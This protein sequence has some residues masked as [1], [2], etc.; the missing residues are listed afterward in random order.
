M[1]LKA[2]ISLSI[3]YIKNICSCDEKDVLT[4]W[5]IREGTYHIRGQFLVS[6]QNRTFETSY[7][8]AGDSFSIS[9]IKVVSR[10]DISRVGSKK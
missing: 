6:K 8:D 1:P 5:C 7:M 10:K 9:E 3:N 4:V 2:F